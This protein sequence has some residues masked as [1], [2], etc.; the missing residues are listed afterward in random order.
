M[1]HQLLLPTHP[2]K[3][4]AASSSH[5]PTPCVSSPLSSSCHLSAKELKS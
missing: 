4:R 1:F 2:R 3:V 5:F